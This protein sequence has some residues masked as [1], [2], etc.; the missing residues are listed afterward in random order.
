MSASLFK[1]A[2]RA[3]GCWYQSPQSC[4][5]TSTCRLFIWRRQTAVSRDRTS[6]QAPE[7][8]SITRW[9]RVS[10]PATK[11]WL[12]GA[13]FFSSCNL[14]ERAVDPDRTHAANGVDDESHRDLI[15]AAAPAH[16]LDDGSA[17]RRWFAFARSPSGGCLP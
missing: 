7:P 6:P 12:T 9:P 17:H 10:T 1:P 3:R 13:F 2:R 15:I 14:N 8:R 4:V 5:T 11:S 16:H